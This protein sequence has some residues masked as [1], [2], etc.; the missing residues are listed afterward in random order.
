MF[1]A[2]ETND[3]SEVADHDFRFHQQIWELADHRLLQD[4]LEGITTQI[5]IYLAVQT[6]LY[7]DLAESVS[8]HLHLLTALGNHDSKSGAMVM[9][10]HLQ[11]AGNVVLGYYKEKSD[12]IY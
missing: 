9:R 8:D 4:V 11:L 5:R 1:K 3:T 7:D 12:A 10:D 2:A 6:Q